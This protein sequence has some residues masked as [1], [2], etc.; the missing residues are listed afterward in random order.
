MS[1]EKKLNPLWVEPVEESNFFFYRIDQHL[2]WESVC[3]EVVPENGLDPFTSHSKSHYC[4]Y[5][6]DQSCVGEKLPIEVAA[7]NWLAE[8]NSK[9][10]E[11]E[12]YFLVRKVGTEEVLAYFYM[13]V[14]SKD[15]I[16]PFYFSFKYGKTKRPVKVNGYNEAIVFLLRNLN[17]I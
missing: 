4:Y 10:Y 12:I 3:V 16:P 1:K 8:K 14:R 9:F 5:S 13:E 2:G 17:L 6:T 11:S 7:V 15:Q